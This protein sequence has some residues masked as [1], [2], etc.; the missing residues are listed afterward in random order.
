MYYHMVSPY[1]EPYCLLVATSDDELPRAALPGKLP[2]LSTSK[3]QYLGSALFR[4]GQMVGVMD[5]QKTLWARAIAGEVNN[6]AYHADGRTL[7]L[8][9]RGAP[10]VSVDASGAMPRIAIGIGIVP[11]PQR[12]M[13][14]MAALDAKV[15]AEIMD[16]L[17][18]LKS[19]GVDPIHFGARAAARFP[20]VAAFEAYGWIDRMWDAEFALDIIWHDAYTL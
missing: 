18:H 14:D 6:F 17:L 4:G 8:L 1:G 15:R 10:K 16:M 13:P 3:N 11:V 12:E 2:A 7:R 9:I 20:S 19:L 5:G